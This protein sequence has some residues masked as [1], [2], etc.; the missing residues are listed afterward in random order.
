MSI[1]KILKISEV[2]NPLKYCDFGSATRCLPFEAI[3]LR[4]GHK[5]TFAAK[6][7]FHY[8]FFN[9]HIPYVYMITIT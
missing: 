8:L 7:Y 4:Q 2:R 6:M 1:R 9:M 5:L 3:V